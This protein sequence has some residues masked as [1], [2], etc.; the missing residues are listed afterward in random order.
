MSNQIKSNQK[1]FIVSSTVM[2]IHSN[3]HG[4]TFQNHL[5]LCLLYDTTWGRPPYWLSTC[6]YLRGRLRL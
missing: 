5:G 3:H 2:K 4:R 1:A 6:L